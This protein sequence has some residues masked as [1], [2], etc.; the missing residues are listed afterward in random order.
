M[1]LLADQGKRL[2]K[3]EVIMKSHVID[4]IIFRVEGVSQKVTKSDLG[5][6]MRG[7]GQLMKKLYHAKRGEVSQNDLGKGGYPFLVRGCPCD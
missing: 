5:E 7:R 2:A 3:I 1:P 4:N 6:R